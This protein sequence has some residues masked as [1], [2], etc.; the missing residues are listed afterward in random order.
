MLVAAPVLGS[1]K[2]KLV[3][4]ASVIS[5]GREAAVTAQGANDEEFEKRLVSHLLA[6]ASIVR[7]QMI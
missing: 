3:D 1:G 2:S 7:R 5:T 6:G 4:I